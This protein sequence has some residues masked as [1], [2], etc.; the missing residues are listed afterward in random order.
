MLGSSFVVLRHRL[1][2]KEIRLAYSGDVGRPH[3]PIIRDPDALAKLTAQERQACQKFWA[4]VA[5]VLQRARPRM[6]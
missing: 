2:G 4:D 1:N 6:K 3:T 5:A